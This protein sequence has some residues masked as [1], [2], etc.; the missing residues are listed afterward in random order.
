MKIR[1][2]RAT[3][4]RPENERGEK[5]QDGIHHHRTQASH[6]FEDTRRHDLF[7]ARHGLIS[8]FL[9]YF[10]RSNHLLKL[11]F[12]SFLHSL[13]DARLR[14]HDQRINHAHDDADDQR[15]NPI[16]S[17]RF[18]GFDFIENFA[19]RNEHI[20]E[21]GEQRSGRRAR[22]FQNGRWLCFFHN[23]FLKMK[24]QSVPGKR[25]FSATLRLAH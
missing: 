7:N 8:F 24:Y 23:E 18:G 25:M 2:E 11:F 19:R 3:S 12:L 16:C 5:Q 6:N 22:R 1:L 20:R 17:R 15:Y 4:H 13:D 9:R 10:P 21:P 14:K